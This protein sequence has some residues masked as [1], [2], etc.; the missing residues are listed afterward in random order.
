MATQAESE[1]GHIRLL[2]RARPNYQGVLQVYTEDKWNVVCYKRNDSL[3][4][5]D[6]AAACRQNG[7]TTFFTY[8]SAKA[9]R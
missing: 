4:F 5:N 3:V 1:E 8:G 2:Y 9:L 7:Y 6:G